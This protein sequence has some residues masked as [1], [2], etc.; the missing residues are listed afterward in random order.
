MRERGSWFGLG[1]GSGR[2][3]G[4]VLKT[5]L[6]VAEKKYD[7]EVTVLLQAIGEAESIDDLSRL[8]SCYGLSITWAN[9]FR[10]L[11]LLIRSDCDPLE[12]D[13]EA[14][15][16]FIND[17]VRFLEDIAWRLERRICDIKSGNPG[18]SGI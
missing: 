9:Y 17:Q 5:L 3:F 16:G 10:S 7:Y 4:R 12:E 6:E 2:D 1:P 8:E 14:V 18:F 11:K 13:T 15:V